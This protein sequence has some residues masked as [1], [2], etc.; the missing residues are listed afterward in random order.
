[1][2]ITSPMHEPMLSCEARTSLLHPA[3]KHDDL[4]TAA[5]VVSLDTQRP[6]AR[7]T[8]EQTMCEHSEYVARAAR[9]MD[10][11][12]SSARLSVPL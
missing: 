9:G 3:Q 10:T 2:Q 4:P 1:M 5:S 6:S 8:A 12:R 7:T 11:T